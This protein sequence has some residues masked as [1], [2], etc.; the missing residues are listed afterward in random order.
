MRAHCKSRIWNERPWFNCHILWIGN[1]MGDHISKSLTRTHFQLTHTWNKRHVQS[2]EAC[3]NTWSSCVRNFSISTISK[4]FV[5]ASP[6]NRGLFG[7]TSCDRISFMVNPLSCVCARSTCL[8]VIMVLE[9]DA[10]CNGC[11]LIMTEGIGKVGFAW[12]CWCWAS[13]LY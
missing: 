4:C 5:G 13:F 1:N 11:Q 3:W 7:S 2:W 6:L 12:L 9:G 10:R 8:V